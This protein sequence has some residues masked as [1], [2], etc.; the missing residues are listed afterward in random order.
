MGGSNVFQYALNPIGWIDPFGLANRPNNGQYH[1]FMEHT[2]AFKDRY[3]SDKE[4]FKKANASFIKQLENNPSFN[5]KMT[6]KYPELPEWTKNGNM[7]SSP[8]WGQGKNKSGLTW[9]HHEDINKL[10]LVDYNDHNKNQGL[11][12]PN[13]KGG[14]GLW[15]GGPPGRSGKLDGSTGKPKKCT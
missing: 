1:V 11:Y 4:Q 10:V 6:K 2:V 14:R 3:A 13:K 15:G 12:H 9:H 5:S 8:N 7:E